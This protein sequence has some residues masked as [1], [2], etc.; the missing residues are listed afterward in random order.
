MQPNE[1]R[2]A[3]ELVLVTVY[4]R[5]QVRLPE[6]VVGVERGHVDDRAV[7]AVGAVEGAPVDWRFVLAAFLFLLLELGYMISQE[8]PAEC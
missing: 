5:V 3:E 8:L 6:L 2:E 1:A 4:A 7:D